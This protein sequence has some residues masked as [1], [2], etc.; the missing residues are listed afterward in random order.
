MGNDNPIQFRDLRRQYENMKS[1]IDKAI[2]E[3][4][5]F[6]QFIS[7]PKVRE[8]E[9]TLAAYT[10]RKHCITCAN[11]TDAISIALQA[12][13]VGAGD[14]V[15]VPDF[16]FFSSG[17]SPATI[18]ATPIFVDVDRDTY[19]IDPTSLA[20]TVETVTGEGKLTPRAVVAV[21]LFG[22]PFDYSA[23]RSICEKYG[24]ILLEDAAQGFGGSYKD[25]NGSVHMACSLGDVSATSFFPAK[26]LG[27]YG[28]GGAIF[29]DDD[30]IADLCRSIAVHGKDTKNPDNPNAK[31]N[32]IR[33]GRNSR[34]D[35]LQAAVLQ[36][37]F[38]VFRDEE[39]ERINRISAAYSE[40]LKDIDG[41][42]TPTVQDG[43]FSSWAQYTIQLP[44][45][46]NRFRLQSK[47]RS[48]GVPTN[49]YYMTPMHKQRAFYNTRSAV[50]DCPVTE[51][52]CGRVLC[53]P[54]HPYMKEMEVEYVAKIFIQALK[55]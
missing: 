3:V 32:N 10:D 16:T 42:K 28:D 27:C 20:R 7:G 18:G 25:G 24:M 5:S 21:D 15:F 22:Q 47:L 44:P 51:E 29:T 38:P 52:L 26:P 35:T 19:N 31:Y 4:I 9:Q 46:T 6:A 39:L 45:N 14:A 37:K 55:K 40:R 53:L 36:A 23:V 13:G 41:L 17:E 2:S 49:I 43:N 33:L 50:A 11:G 8:L 12:H 1:E 30:R 34:L 48:K 54:I